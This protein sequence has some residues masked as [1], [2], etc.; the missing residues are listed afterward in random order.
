MAPKWA[1]LTKRRKNHK[2]ADVDATWNPCKDQI[3]E[4]TTTGPMT[5]LCGTL[6]VRYERLCYLASVSM[7][8]WEPRLSDSHLFFSR[9]FLYFTVAFRHC[10]DA[11]M[12]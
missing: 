9:A 4:H 5:H 7:L 1:S 2:A 6:P 3:L 12:L 11:S 8:A 10:L